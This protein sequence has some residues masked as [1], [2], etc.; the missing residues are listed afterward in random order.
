MLERKRRKSQIKYGG[1]LPRDSA[2]S[3]HYYRH[4]LLDYFAGDDF[5]IAIPSGQKANQQLP[6]NVCLSDFTSQRVAKYSHWR[7]PSD[8]IQAFQTHT[9][10]GKGHK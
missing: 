1:I 10:T 6:Q 3:R 5:K 2:A 4:T 9:I 8:E 7:E